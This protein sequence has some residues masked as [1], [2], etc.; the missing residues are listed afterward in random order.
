MENRRRKGRW[1]GGR[2]GNACGDGTV[3][4]K[5]LEA[6]RCWRSPG[7]IWDREG[8]FAPR[9]LEILPSTDPHLKDT[10]VSWGHLGNLGSVFCPVLLA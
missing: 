9:I 6:L 1:P 5:H 10:Q 4:A 3:S 7:Y 8:T 2:G